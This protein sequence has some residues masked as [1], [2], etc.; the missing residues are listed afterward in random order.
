[1]SLGDFDEN[2]E[3]GQ[4]WC[5]SWNDEDVKGNN[6]YSNFL[7]TKKSLMSYYTVDFI[8]GFW[9]FFIPVTIM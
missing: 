3:Q 2:Y 8:L 4:I 9:F 6:S 5:G 7:S 1:M